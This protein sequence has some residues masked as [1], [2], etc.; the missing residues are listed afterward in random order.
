VA[1]SAAPT[2]TPSEPRKSRRFTSPAMVS[3]LGERPRSS[4][5]TL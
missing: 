1:V 4:D 3:L 5:A 2:V